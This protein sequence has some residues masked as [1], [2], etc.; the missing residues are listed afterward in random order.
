[1]LPLLRFVGSEPEAW[2]E[3]ASAYADLAGEELDLLGRQ[4]SRRALCWAIA[5][6]AGLVAATLGG[7]ALMLWALQPA[8]GAAVPWMLFAV[9]GLPALIAIVAAWCATSAPHRAPLAELRAQ[10]RHDAMLLRAALHEA[11]AS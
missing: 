8:G 9:P 2:V 6:S 3:H 4:W 7:S 5:C 11:R 10:W 1:M